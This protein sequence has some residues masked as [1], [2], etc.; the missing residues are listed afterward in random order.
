V[1]IVI[2]LLDE[3]ELLTLRLVKTTLDRVSLLQLSSASTRS[4]VSCLCG[5]KMV[6]TSHAELGFSLT[7]MGWECR[8]SCSA[9]KYRRVSR[10]NFF[11]LL[12]CQP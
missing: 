1:W 3:R 12:P 6:S 2:R 7:G 8:L 10:P 11:S 9:F 5:L 4:F